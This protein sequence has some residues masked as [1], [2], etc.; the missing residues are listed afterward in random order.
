MGAGKGDKR[1]PYDSKK[2]DENYDRIFRKTEEEKE[3]I[4]DINPILKEKKEME[5]KECIDNI[6][7]LT[8]NHFK[9]HKENSINKKITKLIIENTKSF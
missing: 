4:I 1:R 3:N 9:Q 8:E 6:L 7:K 2:W 5:E